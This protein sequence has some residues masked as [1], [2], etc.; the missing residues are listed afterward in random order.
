MRTKLFIF[1]FCCLSVALFAQTKSG[2]FKVTG[3][4]LDSLSREPVAYAT[5]KIAYAGH[6]QKAVKMLVTDVKGRFEDTL[7][8]A[9]KYQITFSSVGNRTEVRL[10]EVSQSQPKADLGTVYISEATEELGRV[11]VLAQ[12]PLVKVEE[13]P[14]G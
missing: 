2:G 6:P 13:P 7:P 11:T 10:F 12:K 9:G 1:F 3:L 14:P 4:L 8:G 5:I